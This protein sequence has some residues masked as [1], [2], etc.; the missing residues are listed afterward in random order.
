MKIKEVFTEPEIIETGSNFIIEVKVQ[1]GLTWDELK[2][3]TW[4]EVK[5]LTYAQLKGD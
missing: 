5:L 2:E 1:D 4:D 3:L